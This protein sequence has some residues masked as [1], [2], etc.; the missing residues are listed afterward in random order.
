VER[1][2]ASPEA[3]N[4]FWGETP[5]ESLSPCPVFPEPV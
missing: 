3:G 2:S 1:L 4:L 5:F